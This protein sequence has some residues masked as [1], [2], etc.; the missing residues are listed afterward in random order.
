VPRLLSGRSISTSLRMWSR[1]AYALEETGPGVLLSES[2]GGAVALM[3]ALARPGLVSTFARYPGRLCI[4][5]ADLVGS[6][7]PRSPSH[8]LTRPIREYFFLGS[9]ALDEEKRTWWKY[10]AVVP[11]RVSGH[12]SR[13]LCDLDLLP[14]L[15]QVTPTVV[16]A[17]PNDRVVS[18]TAGRLLA[19]RFPWGKLIRASA[20]GQAALVYPR[21]NVAEWLKEERLWGEGVLI[22]FS[23]TTWRGIVCNTTRNEF[24]FPFGNSGRARNVEPCRRS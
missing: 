10:T 11:M 13:H 9:G 4:A 15:H 8:T 23:P 6:W 18:A 16:F 19:K 20:T 21:V 7:L 12:C 3:V 5:V 1:S 22:P 17:A 14:C 24:S 2:F